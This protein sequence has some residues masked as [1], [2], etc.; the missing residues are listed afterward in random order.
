[1]KI[2]NKVYRYIPEKAYNRINDCIVSNPPLFKYEKEAFYT[3]VDMFTRITSYSKNV[4]R[5]KTGLITISSKFFQKFITKNHA[6]CLK[7]LQINNIIVCDRIKKTSKSYGYN[8]KHDLISTLKKVE[9]NTDSNVTRRIIINRNKLRNKNHKKL[10]EEFKMMKAYFK[11]NFKID[12]NKALKYL[13]DNLS[14]GKISI[15]QFN[16]RFITINMIND[17]ELYFNQNKTNNRI[18]SNLTNLSSDIRKFLFDTKFHHIDCKNSQPSLINIVL[19][20]IMTQNQY[21]HSSLGE[22]VDNI[23]T[24][25][26]T[27]KEL[28]KLRKSPFRNKKAKEEFFRFKNDTLK[29]DLYLKL[30]ENFQEYYGKIIPRKEIKTIMYKVFFSNNYSYIKE[31]E[32]FKKS[33]PIIYQIIYNMKQEK[34]NRFALCLQNIESHIFIDRICKKLCQEGIIPMTIHDSVIV[35]EKDIERTLEIMKDVYYEILNDTP[36]FVVESL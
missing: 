9:M 10:T 21:G 34:H 23:L 33:Y 16:T 13:E 32:I 22:T 4:K 11:K 15:N 8:I 12:Y 5:T 20:F 29:N 6:S 35:P 31:K 28:G 14:K 24:K 17:E 30:Q 26:L 19:E 1:M 27:Q 18:D 36:Q 7:W 3:I 2:R 25:H